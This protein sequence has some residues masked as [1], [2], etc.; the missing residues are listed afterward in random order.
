[1]PLCVHIRDPHLARQRE[2]IQQR[3]QSAVSIS[4]GDRIA[5]NTRLLISEVA[6][7]REL[8]QLK[9]LKWLIL[10][11]AGVPIPLRSELDAL[12]QLQ[13]HN[14]HYNSQS[15]AETAISLLLCASKRLLALDQHFRQGNWTPREVDTRHAMLAGSHCMLLG[16]GA[17]GQKIAHLLDALGA[18]VSV[19][20]KSPNPQLAYPCLGPDDWQQQLATT[21]HLIAALPDTAETRGMISRSVLAKLPNHA[22][23]VNVGRASTVDEKAL[24]EALSTRSIAAAGIDVWWNYP[25]HFPFPPEPNQTPPP[26][27]PSKYPYHNLDNVIMLPHRG[28]DHRMIQLQQELIQSLCLKIQ[29][30]AEGTPL[31][32]RIDPRR[33]Y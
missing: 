1:M 5:P 26:C 18:R 27:Y 12:P 7:A 15:V 28:S 33:G 3:L 29:A 21:D 16:F 22:T 24:F 6:T 11:C 4:Y 13:V 17:I 23:L 32:D 2:A 14:C 20:K 8:Q 9:Q 30:A 19:V 10:P 25:A 31:P